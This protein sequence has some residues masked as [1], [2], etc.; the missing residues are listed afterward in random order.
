[1]QAKPRITTEIAQDEDI[2]DFFDFE[3]REP[4]ARSELESSCGVRFDV[5]SSSSGM[6]EYDNDLIRMDEKMKFI[7]T[8]DGDED[9]DVGK[10]QKRV[11]VLEQDSALKDA[12][13]SSLQARVF[14][15][16]QI[17]NQLQGDVNLQMSVVF[18]LKSKLEKKSGQEFAGEHDDPMNVAQHERTAEE[19]AAADAKRE[20]DLNEYL[21]A[22][23]K[24]KK[25]KK[26]KKK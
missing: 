11:V 2:P 3:V 14:T 12:Q 22:A 5:G 16:D 20:A 19:K 7:E 10:M 18:Y 1:M 15:K 25:K 21:A 24:K 23:Q 17:I 4:T 26:K 8:L 13:I 6:S 9:E